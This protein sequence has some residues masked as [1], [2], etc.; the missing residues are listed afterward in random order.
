MFL[1]RS[2]NL[3]ICLDII[4]ISWSFDI[5]MAALDNKGCVQVHYFDIST[6]SKEFRMVNLSPIRFLKRKQNILITDSS[7]CRHIV[8]QHARS[9]SHYNQGSSD[10]S[11]QI[12]SDSCR[13]G[14]CRQFDIDLNNKIIICC[15]SKAIL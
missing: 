10:L 11:L 7:S 13:Q 4:R 14:I 8:Q 3:Y 15:S 6:P 9:F 5:L 1:I 12:R 2:N